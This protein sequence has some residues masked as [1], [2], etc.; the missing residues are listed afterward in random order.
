MRIKDLNMNYQEWQRESLDPLPA[1]LIAN[2]LFG[3]VA[4]KEMQRAE[5]VDSALVRALKLAYPRDGKGNKNAFLTR[6]EHARRSFWNSLRGKY[7]DFLRALA[8]SDPSTL[9]V[10]AKEL[11]VAWKSELERR[12]RATLDVAIRDL[13]GN[14]EL[15]LRTEVTVRNSFQRSLY[16]IMENGQAKATESRKRGR[17]TA[18]EGAA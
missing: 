18:K 13:D 8:A 3:N 16:F 1:P 14:A 10:S 5:E 7:M 4:Q 17:T 11:T 9:D 15:L 2:S 6:I 12:G